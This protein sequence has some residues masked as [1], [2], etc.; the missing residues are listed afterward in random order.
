[1][2]ALAMVLDFAGISP[3]PARDRVHV[4][5]PR[6]EPSEPEPPSADHVEAA[7]AMLAVPY[8]LG[9]LIL[10][11]TGVRVGYRCARIA[12]RRLLWWPV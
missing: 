8:L 6:E 12:T 9:L 5:L 11:A 1:V 10:D 7:A 3:N 4:R 2:T